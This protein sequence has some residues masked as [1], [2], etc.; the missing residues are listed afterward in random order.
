MRK[1]LTAL[2]VIGVVA[3]AARAGAPVRR[4]HRQRQRIQAGVRTRSLTP[5]ETRRLAREQQHIRNLEKQVTADGVVTPAEKA[6]LERARNRASAHIA[7]EKHDGQGRVSRPGRWRRWHPKVPA[8][9]YRHHLRFAHAIVV[10][11]VEPSY[12]RRILAME[13][14]LAKLEAAM[15]SDAKLTPGERRRLLRALSEATAV[16]FWLEDGAAGPELREVIV[17][18]IHEDTLTIEET[19]ELVAQMARLLELRRLLGG[20]EMRASVRE[21]L[22]EEFAT[23]ASQLYQD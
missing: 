20:E 3:S 13:E 5:A 7:K 11:S 12:L 2:V 21:E 18:Q 19:E 16:V 1:W 8:R 9:W 4:A 14:R 17:A 6:L 15:L 22:E 10:G 23:L